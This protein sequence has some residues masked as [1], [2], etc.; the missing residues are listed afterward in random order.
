MVNVS[1]SVLLS[2]LAIGY[3]PNGPHGGFVL[4]VAGVSPGGAPMLVGVRAGLA[5]V[6]ALG[7]ADG[8]NVG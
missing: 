2:K 6:P 8:A 7:G 5:L 1:A 4:L 3:E